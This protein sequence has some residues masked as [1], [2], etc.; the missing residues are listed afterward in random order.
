VAE[1]DKRRLSKLFFFLFFLKLL[2]ISI[3]VHSSAIGP[4]IRDLFAVCMLCYVNDQALYLQIWNLAQTVQESINCLFFHVNPGQS[5]PFTKKVV[6]QDVISAA[7][8]QVGVGGGVGI[9]KIGV[10]QP[11]TWL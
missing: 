4:K 5:N 7:R 3:G 2:Q 9:L 10:H 6:S 1:S 8:Q 11:E